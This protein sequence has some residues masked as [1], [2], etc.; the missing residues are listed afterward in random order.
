MTPKLAILAVLAAFGAFV[1]SMGA[2]HVEVRSKSPQGDHL[3]VIVPAMV[4]PAAALLVPKDKIREVSRELRQW[5]PAIQAASEEL[6][7]CPDGPLVEVDDRHEHVK[8]AK[9]EGTL[10]V[11]VDD[12]TETVHVSLPLLAATYACSRLA[13]D[14]EAA[15]EAKPARAI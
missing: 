5:L 15:K 8:I 10:V 3:R 13:S 12:Q 11:D 7:R 14:A 6:L 9:I 2:V 4:L 1:C